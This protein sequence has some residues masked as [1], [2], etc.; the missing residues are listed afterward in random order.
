[1]DILKNGLDTYE[2]F[3]LKGNLTGSTERNTGELGD[4]YD[5]IRLF[6]ASTLR[7]PISGFPH[8]R[9]PSSTLTVP[10]VINEWPKLDYHCLFNF[11]NKDFTSRKNLRL[12]SSCFSQSQF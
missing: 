9:C 10:D 12:W 1:M 4:I 11:E 8:F 2:C 5:P 6:Y 3:E 7:S